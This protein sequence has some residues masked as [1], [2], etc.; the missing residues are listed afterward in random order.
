MIIALGRIDLL[1]ATWPGANAPRGNRGAA[2]HEERILQWVL[3]HN[4]HC[5]YIFAN[6]DDCGERPD[7]WGIANQSLGLPVVW[8][9]ALITLHHRMLAIRSSFFTTADVPDC[10]MNMHLALALDQDHAPRRALFADNPPSTVIN[11]TMQ[12]M[13]RYHTVD[14]R[15]HRQSIRDGSGLVAIVNSP[16]I[17]ERPRLEEIERILGFQ[18]GDT[19]APGLQPEWSRTTLRWN[20]LGDCVDV[21]AMAHILNVLPWS[22]ESMVERGGD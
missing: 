21:R 2:Y 12:P 9:V 5:H 13:R 14:R 22:P 17:F 7:T 15:H 16:G 20:V 4:P 3:R 11:V 8:D 6:T 18:A 19:N 10:D 1:A